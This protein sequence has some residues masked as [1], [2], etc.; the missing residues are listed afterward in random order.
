MTDPVGHARAEWERARRAAQAVLREPGGLRER[1]RE[2]LRV[3]VLPQIEAALA[4]LERGFAPAELRRVNAFVPEA[5]ESLAE[6]DWGLDPGL[7]GAC[8][9]MRRGLDAL[10]A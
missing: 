2:L 9:H 5:I 8:D 4:D 7:A 10:A 6:E 3:S 1:N